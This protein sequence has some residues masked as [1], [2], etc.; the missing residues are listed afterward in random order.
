MGPFLPC[1][2]LGGSRPSLLMGQDSVS[3]QGSHCPGS[4]RSLTWP[5]LGRWCRAQ[6]RVPKGSTPA[7]P[8]A[9]AEGDPGVPSA[10]AQGRAHQDPHPRGRGWLGWPREGQG[11]R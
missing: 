10:Q 7:R 5:L 9:A 2:V 4:F 3:T 8:L 6:V 1:A 11:R